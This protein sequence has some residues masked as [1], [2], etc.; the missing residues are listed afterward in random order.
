MTDNQY[1]K[2]RLYNASLI[3]K[4]NHSFLY[5]I[6]EHL[7]DMQ[8]HKLGQGSFATA[9]S[10]FSLLNFISKIIAILKKGNEVLITEEEVSEY[11]KLKEIIKSELPTEW[12]KIKKYFKKPRVGDINETEAFVLFIELCPIDFGINKNNK[13]EI[14]NIWRNYRNKLT[15]IISLA[16][17]T[18]SGQMLINLS[19]E[20]SQEGMYLSNLEFI[21][22][23]ISSYKPFD[24]P[25]EEVKKVFLEKPKFDS[26]TLQ[27]IV[28]DKCHVDR[29][30]I[31]SQMVIDWIIE[32][33]DS[34]KFEEQNCKI[35][36]NWLK[37]ELK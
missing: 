20:P 27:H 5:L 21:K 32:E 25:S 26:K 7:S 18:Q 14:Q 9:I 1:I 28:K 22:E 13:P 3:I 10:L 35:L 24:I 31:V 29:L 4:D 8:K 30:I 17:D 16:G 33:I 37:N 11:N 34:N 19:M 6:S 15:H 2:N 36:V 23:R 12:K